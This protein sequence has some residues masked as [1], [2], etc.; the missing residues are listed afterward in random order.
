MKDARVPI[1]ERYHWVHRHFR[2]V[3]LLMKTFVLHGAQMI[4]NFIC[5]SLIT[6]QATRSK[7]L[8]IIISDRSE[9][10]HNSTIKVLLYLAITPIF[11]TPSQESPLLCISNGKSLLC[12][13][14]CVQQLSC[15][16]STLWK[17]K[18]HGVTILRNLANQLVNATCLPL[19]L[20]WGTV[21]P[22]ANLTQTHN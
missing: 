9:W 7:K 15:H 12:G 1:A 14:D 13:T 11:S 16:L 21:P 3:V 18:Q 6:L 22:R 4:L 8:S 2:S 20:S 5:H 19:V 10:V 17:S